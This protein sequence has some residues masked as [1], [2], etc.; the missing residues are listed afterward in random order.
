MK[1]EM[2]TKDGEVGEVGEFESPTPSVEL[3]KYL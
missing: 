2:G 3:A 1:M